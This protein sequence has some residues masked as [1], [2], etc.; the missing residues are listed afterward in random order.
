MRLTP[1]LVASFIFTALVPLAALGY[2]SYITARPALEREVV[3]SMVL[4][5]DAVEG[6][7]AFVEKRKPVFKNR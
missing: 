5:A 2:L 4:T 7:R 6:L 1:K 3:N